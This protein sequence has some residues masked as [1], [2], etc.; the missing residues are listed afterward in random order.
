MAHSTI[1]ASGFDIALSVLRRRKWVG[2]IVFAAALSLAVP[3]PVFLP[4]IYRGV[5]TVMVENQDASAHLVRG[6]SVPELE[7]RLVTIQQ[8]L[9]SRARLGDLITRLDLYPSWRGHAS[10]EA[11]VQRLRRDIR[12]ELSGTE[13]GRPTTSGV[14]IAYIGLD[15]R[16]AAAVPNALAAL[17][18]EEN[19]KIRERQTG[20][21]AHFLKSQ[22]EIAGQAV[23]LQQLQLNKFKEQRSGQLPEQVSINMVT[24]ERLNTRLQLN[25]NDQIRTRERLDGLIG[26]MPAGGAAADPLQTLKQRLADLQVKFTDKHPDVIQTK[27]QIS[28]M[29][30]E[31]ASSGSGLADQPSTRHEDP[32]ITSTKA[33]LAALQSQERILRSE[34]AAYEQRIQSTPGVEQELKGLEREYQTLKD[35]Y[36]S[37]QNRY[38]DA[39]LAERLEQ[40]KQAESFRILDA[41]VLPTGPAAPNRTRLLMMACF[42]AVA[43]G[44]GMMLLAEHLDTS[45][46]TV[47]ELR[48]FTTLP[49][50]ASIPYVRS[51]PTLSDAFR[52]ALAAVA[53]IGVCV[54]L[55]GFA[56][57]TAQ[58]N[59]QLVWTLSAPQL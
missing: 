42:F 45:F 1:R 11:I 12:V 53:V 36:D 55:A 18:V 58:E 37:M 31:R 8:E 16:S 54:L 15:A 26:L 44:I 10:Q 20:Q 21:M 27:A 30:R 33:E 17:Y 25:R 3:F 41:A 7:T 43:A 29:E 9:L 47:G 14:Q 6:S 23:E 46:H 24:L 38:E 49:V 59:T 57:W 56:Y 40:S 51:R 4:D 35:S 48:Q 22:L 13:R 52:V 28:Q 34:I 39:Q 32:V 2:L 5:A 50:L 19:R